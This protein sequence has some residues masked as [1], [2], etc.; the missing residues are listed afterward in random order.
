MWGHNHHNHH[1]NQYPPGYIGNPN[2]LWYTHAPWDVLG[3]V[4]TVNMVTMDTTDIMVTTDTM[5]INNE[6]SSSSCSSDS[7]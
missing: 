5:V 2:G 4:S 6:T 3:N 1:G 7:N